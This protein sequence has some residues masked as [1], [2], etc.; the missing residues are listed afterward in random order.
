MKQNLGW[1]GT[2]NEV[3]SLGERQRRGP[4]DGGFGGGSGAYVPKEPFGSKSD[5]PYASGN[6][7]VLQKEADEAGGASPFNDPNMRAALAQRNSAWDAN[8][9]VMEN[10]NRRASGLDPLVAQQWNQAG[11]RQQDALR[12]SAAALVD[13]RHRAAVLG[14]Q[15]TGLAGAGVQASSG[16]LGAQMGSMQ[17]GLQD[18]SKYGTA[19]AEQAAKMREQTA[20]QDQ[21]TG[22]L[23]FK[24]GSTLDAEAQRWEDFRRQLAENEMRRRYGQATQQIDLDSQ[25]RANQYN[26]LANV[27]Q[28]GARSWSSSDDKDKK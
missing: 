19:Q 8:E 5:S 9:S 7:G 11:L 12:A 24:V 25:N 1:V 6:Q 23:R 15:A 13:P 18:L 20:W 21:F 27:V 4:S 28:T 10:A 14:S 17:Q 2:N 22:G 16:A 26:T 3:P